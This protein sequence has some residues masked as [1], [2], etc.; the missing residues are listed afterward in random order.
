MNSLIKS[1]SLA[2][3]AVVLLSGCTATEPPALSP[4]NPADANVHDSLRML[5]N[6]LAKDETTIAIARELGVTQA[7]AQGAETMQH[8]MRN[9]S[10]MQ[11]GGGMQSHD[12]QSEN[13]KLADQMKKTSA[14]M[15]A[16]ATKLKQ[17]ERESSPGTVIYT[18]PMHPQIHSNQPGKCPICGMTLVSKEGGHEEH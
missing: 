15:K 4:N 5:R 6:V 18:C 3:V 13:Q 14:E 11:H 10:G 1:S 2:L 9:M 17:R 7:H 8:E 12:A 16:T